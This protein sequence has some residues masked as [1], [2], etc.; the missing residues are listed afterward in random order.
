MYSIPE[1][2]LYMTL[3]HEA[4]DRL[5]SYVANEL[6]GTCSDDRFPLNIEQCGN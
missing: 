6:N 4:S 5:M 3:C 1:P 2:V